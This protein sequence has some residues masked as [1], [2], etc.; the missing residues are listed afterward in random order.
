MKQ[1]NRKTGSLYER[2]AAAYLEKQGLTILERNYRCRQGE[3]DLVARDKEYLV[4]VEVKYRSGGRAGSSLAAVNKMKQ[5]VIS[6]VARYYLT[7]KWHS[8]DIPC[9]FDVIGID[10]EQFSWVKNAFEWRI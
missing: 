2:K 9:R 7:V 1:N 10:G 5:K 6:E 4:F 3:I 8:S